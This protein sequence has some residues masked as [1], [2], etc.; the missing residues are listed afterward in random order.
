M[1]KLGSCGEAVFVDDS[2]ET[3]AT[4][5]A[6]RIGRITPNTGVLR[7]GGASFKRAMRPVAL[8]VVDVDPEHMLEVA[9]VHDQQ[10]VQ[11]LGADG[12]DEALGDR[13]RLR[14]SHRR[15]DDLDAF[16]CEDSVEVAGELAVA[17][18]DQ[19]AKRRGRS[20]SVQAN[21]RACWVTQAP[22]GFAVQPA[23]WTRRL[24]SS[25]KK[26]T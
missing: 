11:A 3:V 26:S 5:D 7:S 9:P 25:M 17:V 4:L 19:E 6:S 14:R 21:W 22:V 15:L 13:V 16:A 8:V 24:P 20:F 18:A 23:M 12:A 2:A 1:R 10:P